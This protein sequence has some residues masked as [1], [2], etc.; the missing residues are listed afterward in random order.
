M[1][2]ELAPA[3]TTSPGFRVTPAATWRQLFSPNLDTVRIPSAVDSTVMGAE[4]A[5]VEA[6]EGGTTPEPGL[7]FAPVGEDTGAAE[8]DAGAVAARDGD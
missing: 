1:A 5:R 4:T 2:L 3:F 6:C 7:E 8:A